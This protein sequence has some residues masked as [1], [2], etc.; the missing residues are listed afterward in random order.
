MQNF[1]DYNVNT[2]R[3][4]R[5]QKRYRKNRF[6]RRS[7]RRPFCLWLPLGRW[8]THGRYKRWGWGR[9]EFP[10][11]PEYGKH[12][13]RSLGKFVSYSAARIGRITPAQTDDPVRG[14]VFRRVR[15]RKIRNIPRYISKRPRH[16]VPRTSPRFRFH[17]IRKPVIDSANRRHRYRNYAVEASTNVRKNARNPLRTIFIIVVYLLI[18]PRR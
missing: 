5:T 4:T 2:T 13:A 10:R 18:S 7:P 1:I 3:T 15:N 11:S 14:Y 9:G 6:V 12:A 16:S 8:P 17:G